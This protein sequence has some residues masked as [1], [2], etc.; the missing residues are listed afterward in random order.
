MSDEANDVTKALAAF[1]APSIR[2]H[3]FGQAS[4]R[5]SS[6][7]LPRR[8]QSPAPPDTL[9]PAVEQQE[10]V[11]APEPVV[12]SAPTPPPVAESRP[13]P[14]LRQA[15][16]VRMPP[17]E[18]SPTVAPPPRPLAEWAAPV[19]QPAPR[20]MVSTAPLVR[21]SNPAPNFPPAPPPIV[22]PPLFPSA[23][24]QRSAPQAPPMPS[25]ESPAWHQPPSVRG[26]APLPASPGLVAAPSGIA[27]T[28][29]AQGSAAPATAAPSRVVTP[30]A[31]TKAAV[32]IPARETSYAASS[33]KVASSLKSRSLAE[34]FEFLVSASSH[35]TARIR[36]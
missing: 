24:T 3:S 12:R 25:P 14:M 18:P 9:P 19:G 6:V 36:E 26:S 23:S 5:P 17:A 20:A 11:S 34:V 28:N 13:V 7:V 27:S 10:P 15:E 1:G 4:I 22:V 30:D 32:Q 21:S 2:Y 31:L 29:A 35:E 16:P 33:Q 8:V